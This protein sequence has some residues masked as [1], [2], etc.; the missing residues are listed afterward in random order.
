MKAHSLASNIIKLYL[1]LRNPALPAQTVEVPGHF[2]F[3]Y[4]NAFE[5][6][7]KIVFGEL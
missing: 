7:G 1:F 4:A 5:E 2:N 6:D 3:H